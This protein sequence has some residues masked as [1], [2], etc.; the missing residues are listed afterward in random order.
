MENNWENFL[1]NLGEWRGSFTRV[2]LNAEVLDSTPSILTLEGLEN[3]QLVRFRLRRFAQGSYDSEPSQDYIQDYRSVGNQIIFFDTSLSMT[4]KHESKTRLE[5]ASDMSL[6]H[7]SVLPAG[8]QVAVAT[9]HVDSEPL[10]QPDLAGVRSRIED[11]KPTASPRTLNKVVQQAIDTQVFAR[12]Q[13]M[14]ESGTQDA[15]SREI[16]LLTDMSE[17]AWNN[18][19]ESGLRDLLV[20]HDWLK[21]YVIDVSVPNPNNISLTQLTLDREATVGGQSVQVS[22]TVSATPAARSARARASAA[23]R[24]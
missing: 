9:T 13:W 20:Q 2:S 1:K 18:P 17:A 5:Q 10:F 8:S 15:F 21:L 22:T 3:N 4:Y 24:R 19:D 12:E 16:Y 6:N 7:L 23:S 11:L 14:A